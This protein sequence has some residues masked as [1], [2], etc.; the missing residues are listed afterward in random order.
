MPESEEEGEGRKSMANDIKEAVSVAGKAAKE[1]M[2]VKEQLE[3]LLL[4]L[5]AFVKRAGAPQ[6]PEIPDGIPE[7]YLI[8]RELDGKYVVWKI[9]GMTFGF[10]WFLLGYH[11]TR[12]TAGLFSMNEARDK[13]WRDA[14]W[15]P[16]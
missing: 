14:G 1:A 15:K 8:G 6:G 10:D 3:G 16:A 2:K 13:A 12:I 9:A 11:P 7:G 4:R 5:D